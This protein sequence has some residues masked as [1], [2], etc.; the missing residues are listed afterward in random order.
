M[1]TES[2]SY[3]L[4]EH[5]LEFANKVEKVIDILAKKDF[6]KAEEVEVITT[7]STYLIVF[8]GYLTLLSTRL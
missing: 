3:E 5:A 2:F 4:K 7:K 8:I 6:V 1:F